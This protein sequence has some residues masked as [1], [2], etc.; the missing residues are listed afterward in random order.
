MGQAHQTI[1]HTPSLKALIAAVNA[2]KNRRVAFWAAKDL[3]EEGRYPS[4][5]E[6]LARA[7]LD[8][9]RINRQFCI[10]A[11]ACFTASHKISHPA[12]QTSH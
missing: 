12:V 6:V 7:G 5:E 11:I 2:G 10:E 9:T 3:T 4:A 8:T 1:A